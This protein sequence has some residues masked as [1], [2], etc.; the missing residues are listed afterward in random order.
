MPA[1]DASVAIQR[2]NAIGGT[3]IADDHKRRIQEAIDVRLST[4]L[5]NPTRKVDQQLLTEIAN[6]LTQKD[7]TSMTNPGCTPSGILQT[8]AQRL[9]RLGVRSLHEQIVKWAVAPTVV[10]VQERTKVR[11]TYVI[12]P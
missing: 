8:I 11:P 1:C 4:G 7:W 9:R 2:C 6:Y 12:T 5:T 3:R 10:L